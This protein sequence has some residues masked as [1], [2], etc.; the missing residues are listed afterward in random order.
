MIIAPGVVEDR[1]RAGGEGQVDR[2]ETIANA[3]YQSSPI[4][5]VELKKNRKQSRRGGF[6]T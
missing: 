6:D 2:L 3:D 4:V 1:E 5:R